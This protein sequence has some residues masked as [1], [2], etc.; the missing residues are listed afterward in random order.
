M[1]HTTKD[2]DLFC[3]ITGPD[4][5]PLLVF[6]HG[7]GMNLAMFDEQVAFFSEQYRCLVWD[8]P[9]HGR[10]YRL[11]ED[12]KFTESADQLISL[13]DA[14]R[15][16]KAVLVGHSMGSMISQYAA[17][18]YPDRVEGIV[19]IGGTKLK[20]N[21][22]SSFQKFMF[23]ISP[24]FFKLTTE[25]KFF[26][27]LAKSKAVTKEAQKFYEESL[28]KMGRKQFSY[29]W[30]GLMQSFELGIDTPVRH[31][32][33]ICHGEHDSPPTLL[34]EAGQWHKESPDSRL[35]FLP[36]AGHNANM[37]APQLFNEEMA[38]FLNKLAH[39]IDVK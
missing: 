35:V 39:G 36:K 28:L 22:L 12:F 26:Y 29:L 23:Q 24:Y 19:S 18:R 3:D 31:P 2:G 6:T 17:H 14:V 27:R 4:D 9:G 1:I 37:D 34:E 15:G 38:V 30:R 13:M 7:A 10:S 5:G 11:T 25:K 20:A 32:L 33:M 21:E 8:L 16:K